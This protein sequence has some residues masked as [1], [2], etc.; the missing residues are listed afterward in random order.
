MST[1]F[2]FYCIYLF[3]NKAFSE[4]DKFHRVRSLL[5]EKGF[6]KLTIK[7]SPFAMLNTLMGLFTV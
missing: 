4:I 7:E 6:F 2:L 3:F 5:I 1:E